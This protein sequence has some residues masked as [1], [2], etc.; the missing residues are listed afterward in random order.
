MGSSAMTN[1]LVTGGAG[2]VGYHVSKHFLQEGKEVVIYDNF[3]DYYDPLIK[4]MNAKELEELGAK[5]VIGD[6]LDKNNLINT[7]MQEK[8]N[9]IIHLA[10]QPGV[11][12]STKNPDKSIRV[13]VEGTSNVL[14][15]ARTNKVPRVVVTS[16]SSVYGT[17]EYLPMDEKHP[18]NPISYYGASKLSSEQVVNVTRHLYPEIETVI[19]RP[20][21]VVGARQRP[22]MAINLFVSKAMQKETITVLGDGNQTR[23][24]T[25]VENMA[26]A[27]YLA[28]VKEKAKGQDFNV[29]A[30]TRIS[31][32]E[33]LQMVSE[34]TNRTLQLEHK[35]MDKA[36]VRDTFAN[37]DKAKKLLGYNPKK[38]LFDAVEDF[39]EHWLNNNL[40]REATCEAFGPS[41]QNP[42]YTFTSI[43]KSTTKRR[44]RI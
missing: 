1:V 20:F 29:G 8:V 11:R 37:I 41:I 6:I 38:T 32:N 30:G 24:W 36:D 31:V 44:I 17:T 25:H 15:A 34:V 7:M 33:V 28:T 16:S 26:Q 5:V 39:T 13:N 2:F 43:Q 40:G 22:D 3:A 23:D 27:Y 12:Y 42:P 10:A 18:K 4:W 35:K 21:T 14:D 9:A 19:F